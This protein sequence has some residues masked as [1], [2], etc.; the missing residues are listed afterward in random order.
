MLNRGFAAIAVA[1][2]FAARMVSA[3]TSDQTLA[4]SWEAMRL[5]QW[6]DAQAALEGLRIHA[7]EDEAKVCYAEGMLWQFRR[8]NADL[9][10]SRAKFREVLEKHPASPE[11]PWALL[12]LAR[13]ADIDVLKPDP[14]KAAEGYRRVMEQYPASDAATEAA[15]HLP[16]ALWEAQGIKGAREGVQILTRWLEEHPDPKYAAIAELELGRLQ[17][18][19]LEDDAAAVAHLRRAVEAGLRSDPLRH[20]LDYRLARGTPVAR[21]RGCDGI[22]Q[23]FFA[24][25][26]PAHPFVPGQAGF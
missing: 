18:Y 7:P 3:G 11:A 15:I 5:G 4:R 25:V 22:L 14:Q 21:P 23:A 1:L 6:R 20:H 16:L 12:A 24:G 26:S 10:K 17:R 2:L 8:P 13:P 19:P 9:K